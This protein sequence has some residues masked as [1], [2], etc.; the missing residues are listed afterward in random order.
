VRYWLARL[1]RCPF[2]GHRLEYEQDEPYPWC[3]RCGDWFYGGDLD[4]ADV[5]EVVLDASHSNA[6]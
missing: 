5:T 4:I 2:L 3:T 1:V 6:G